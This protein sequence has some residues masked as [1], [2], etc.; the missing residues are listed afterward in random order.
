MSLLWVDSFGQY[1]GPDQSIML[2]GLYADVGLVGTDVSNTPKRNAL[3]AN[4]DPLATNTVF[5]IGNN[6]N[7][8]G[9][10]HLNL[11]RVFL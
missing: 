6:E 5:R 7:F 3:V 1:G 9:F 8:Q 4:P 10:P 2:N 11:R